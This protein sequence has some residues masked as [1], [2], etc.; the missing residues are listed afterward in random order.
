MKNK[1][2]TLIS[3]MLVFAL[4]LLSCKKEKK[5]AE[6]LTDIDGNIYKPVVI[7]DQIWMAENLKTTR[8]KDGTEIAIIADSAIWEN[9]STP[10]Y[11]WYNNDAASFSNTYGALYN[12]YTV[13]T[14]KLCPEGWHIP[15]KEEWLTLREFLGDSLSSG[16]KLKETGTMHWLP[17]NKEAT[18]SS[19]FTALGAGIRYFEGTFASILSYTAFWSASDDGNDE[20]W[21]TGLYYAETSFISDFRNKKHGFSIRCL[22]D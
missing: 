14:G 4:L 19:G 7:G 22:K 18:N 10:A 12:A 16:A 13:N 9:L 20:E 17:P 1:V 21:Y 15:E 11:C 3:I 8:L 6:L 2:F 5:H